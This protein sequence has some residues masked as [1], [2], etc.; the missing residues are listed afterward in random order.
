VLGG[1]LPSKRDSPEEGF[2]LLP[3]VCDDV[4]GSEHLLQNT[5]L[6]A[7]G[8]SRRKQSGLSWPRKEKNKVRAMS[9]PPEESGRGKWQSCWTQ[10]SLWAIFS[11]VTYKVVTTIALSTPV[12]RTGCQHSKTNFSGYKLLSVYR[13]CYFH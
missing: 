9:L 2:V 1:V 10:G 12:F 8:S 13:Y 6:R 11:R 5:E 3:R 4:L 7:E